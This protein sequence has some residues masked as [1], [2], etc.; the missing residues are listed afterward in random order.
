[1][2][3]E[4]KATLPGRSDFFL[5]DVTDMAVHYTSVGSVLYTTSRFGGGDLLAYRIVADGGLTQLD[6]RAIAG[7]AQSGSVNKITLVGDSLYLT[8]VQNAALT[9]IDLAADGSF[10]SVSAV[11]GATLPQQML[12][13]EVA[14]V[15]GQAYLY[16]ITRG[17]DT[18]GTWRINANGT[19]TE[20]QNA[21]VGSQS[22]AALTGLSVAHVG[23]TP[24]LLVASASENALISMTLDSS[25]RPTEAA[26]ISADDG[27][28]I[29]GPSAVSVVAIGG[30]SFGVMGSSAS[31]SLTVVR[32]GANGT[33]QLTDHRL[34]TLNTRFDDVTLLETVVHNDRAYVAAAGADDGVSIFELSPDGRLVHLSTIVDA[35][36]TTLD[37]PSALGF[38]VQ[39]N[40]L[41]LAI[42]SGVEAGLS[43]F[44]LDISGRATPIYGTGAAENLNGTAG[45]DFL[46][47]NG[48]NDTISGGVGDDFLAD[49]TGADLLTGGGGAD[50]F[51]MTADGT[52]DTI[53]D[54]DTTQD[55]L[56][57]SGWSL[58]RSIPV[59][60]FQSTS[61]GAVL[62]LGDE[63]LTIRSADG[64]AITYED[65]LPRITLA[66]SY[67]PQNMVLPDEPDSPVTP[68]NPVALNLMGTAGN[69]RLDGDAASDLL[70]GLAANDTVYGMGGDDTIRGDE[71]ADDLYGNAGSD[72]V[73]GGTG[74]DQLWG[75]I[76]WDTLRGND[77]DDFMWGG[78]G[79]DALG[80]G[81]GNDVIVGNSGADRLYGDDG[82]DVLTG[83]LNADQLWGGNDNDTL[84]GSAGS[85][86]LF[87]GSGDDYLYGNAGA[88]ELEGGNGDDQLAGGV[89]NDT[90]DGGSGN[91]RLQGDNGSDILDGGAGNDLLKG[92]AGHDTLDGGAGDDILSGGIGADQ[93]FFGSGQDQITD[94]QN[95]IDTLVLDAM[96]WGGGERS[97]SQLTAY[98]SVNGDGFV[99]FDFGNGNTLELLN[100][101]SISVLD[102]DFEVM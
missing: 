57:L 75:G 99:S 24:Q 59:S 6:S 71:G 11:T 29:A 8:G 79:Y 18:V 17:S 22:Q 28:G 78:D 50:H 34:D 44:T 42:A 46:T 43:T 32:L 73:E 20:V 94:F 74:N 85:D 30:Q 1:M 23:G 68:V 65:M 70:Q 95:E 27:V 35:L 81:D 87:G 16:G 76:G 88:D 19:V 80:G 90:L 14:V 84:S 52:A 64:N 54:F 4:H 51:I 49:G 86:D 92:N 89:N 82:N 98:A 55:T 63:S 12:G 26:R 2:A 83:G 33:M 66:T 41:H 7:A 96:L 15:G 77:G 36:N 67:I 72:V 25:G 13:A 40:A 101:T 53:S 97:L 3:F 69:D 31:G 9:K 5:T 47:G 61:N 100:V 62:T 91:D 39:N 37:A 56:D 93:F 21:G 48:G 102:N 10:S 45:D 60:M 38:S 58:V